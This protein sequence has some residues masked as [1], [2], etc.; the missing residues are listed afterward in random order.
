VVHRT[1]DPGVSVE[2]GR[3]LAE[4]IPGAKLIESPGDFVGGYYEQTSDEPDRFEEFLTGRR[5]IGHTDRVLS[6]VLFTDLVDSTARA[7]RL[8]DAA[9]S[10]LLA[11]HHHVAQRLVEASRGRVVQTTGDGVL[12]TF[13]GPA[14]AIG[15]TAAI[16]DAVAELG[17]D[18]RAGLHTG[19]I[20]RN[21]ADVSGIAVHLAARVCASAAP[22]QIRVSRT[23]VDLVAGSSLEF[24]DLGSFALKGLPREWQLY[25]VRA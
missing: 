14:R 24:E 12:A 20:E 17:L 7:A 19:E 1:G 21:G 5:D 4:S 23:V 22:G 11:R 18:M 2:H 9:W 25:A 8:G 6:T 13:D 15:T 16:R 10:E 3:F